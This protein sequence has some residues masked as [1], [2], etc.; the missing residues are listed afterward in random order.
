MADVRPFR[1]LRFD[2]SRV[3]LTRTI[4]PPYDVISA[5]EQVALYDASPHNIVRIEYGQELPGDTGE[6]NRY[7]RAARDLLDWISH[8]LIVRDERPAFYVYELEFEW[9]QQRFV[10]HH[11]FC[12]A[13][14]EEWDRRIVRPHEQ[15]L[16]TP[17][18]DRLRLLRATRTQVSPVY[19]LVRQTERAPLLD[20]EHGVTLLDVSLGAQRHRV[21]TVSDDASIRRLQGY[22]AERPLYVAD[23]HHR[24]ETALAY[25]DDRRSTDAS[26][27]GEEPENFVFM[28][29]TPHDDRGLV[30]LPTHRVV[31]RPLP[32]DALERLQPLF[33]VVPVSSDAGALERELAA[34]AARGDTAFALVAP[35]EAVRILCLRDRARA[36]QLMPPAAGR[37][38]KHLDV[39]V[40]QFAILEPLFG[41]DAPALAAGTAISYMQDAVEVKAAVDGGR[42]PCALL[43][44]ATPV[45]QILSVSDED[46]RMPQKSTYFYPKLPTGLLMNPL[47][48]V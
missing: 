30:V 15:T 8:G 4:A 1:A 24:Y 47:D 28:A 46:G 12:V 18:E 35:G 3:D 37:A 20:A 43:M 19:C 2:P 34:Y 13:R 45:D 9:R 33:E 10:R 38:W 26:W 40:L 17:K 23:G 5:D 16:N 41:I 44:N 27:S 32:G 39:N 36:E 31:H 25:R 6:E 14:L 21:S 7:T 11:I 42:A 29:I 22:L 48:A